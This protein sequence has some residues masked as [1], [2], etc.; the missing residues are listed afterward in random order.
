MHSTH[1]MP[2]IFIPN[3]SHSAPQ[4]FS[5]GQPYHIHVH[6]TVGSTTHSCLSCLHYARHLKV[7]AND[8]IRLMSDLKRSS[9]IYTARSTCFATT[10]MAL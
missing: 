1:F 2:S 10:A 5:S 6:V 7:D 3:Y 9:A 4:G 8:L